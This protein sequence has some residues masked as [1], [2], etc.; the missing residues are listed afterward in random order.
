[1]ID[2][3][4][5]LTLVLMTP[6]IT[7]MILIGPLMRLL[8]TKLENIEL[9]IITDLLNDISF[10]TAIASTSVRLHSEFVRLLFLQAYREIDRFFAAS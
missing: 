7:L 5:A 1:M 6:Y 3:E 10:M 2:G 8:L 4:V 9:I